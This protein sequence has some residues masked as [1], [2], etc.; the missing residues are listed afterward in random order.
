[1][2]EGLIWLAA[3]CDAESS[4]ETYTILGN[5]KITTIVKSAN[6]QQR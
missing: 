5:I 6:T 2:D 1:M 3:C 4:P